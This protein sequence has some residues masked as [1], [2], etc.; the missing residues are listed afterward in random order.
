MIKIGDICPLFF[1]PIKNEFQQDIDYI[2]RF[3]ITDRIILQIFSD[4][5]NDNPTV[6]LK[7]K[8]SGDE[9]PLSLTEY[10]IN[11]VTR[12]FSVVMTNLSDSVYAI[13]VDDANSNVNYTSECFPYVQTISFYRRHV[14][15]AILMKIIIPPL[16]IYF[17]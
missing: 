3:Y 1:N 2:Q 9:T 14:L 11:S 4:D 16:I 7:N 17:G 5:V 13:S 15:F 12:M 8:V 6:T 10:Q